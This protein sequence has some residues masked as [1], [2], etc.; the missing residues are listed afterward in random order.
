MILRESKD[1]VLVSVISSLLQNKTEEDVL[2]KKDKKNH[3]A[4]DSVLKTRKITPLHRSLIYK[5]IGTLTEE[6]KQAVKKQLVELMKS[7]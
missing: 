3:L 1:D 2:L 7:L 6:D 5:K 4:T